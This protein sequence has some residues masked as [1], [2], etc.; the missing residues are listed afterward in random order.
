MSKFCQT[1]RCRLRI[2]PE[3]LSF[4]E[5]RLYNRCNLLNPVKVRQPETENSICEILI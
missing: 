4:E 3:M 2:A 1:H 5:V